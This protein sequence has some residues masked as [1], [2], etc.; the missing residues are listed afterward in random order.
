[1]PEGVRT[2][3]WLHLHPAE[4]GPLP[5]PCGLLHSPSRKK[6]V[7]VVPIETLRSHGHNTARVTRLGSRATRDRAMFWRRPKQQDAEE[8][9]SVVIPALVSRELG[10]AAS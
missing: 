2:R 9:W 7:D 5:L 8:T 3:T 6:S 4:F 10:T 1:M